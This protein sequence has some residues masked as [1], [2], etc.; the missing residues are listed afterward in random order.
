MA[1]EYV[2]TVGSALPQNRVVCPL[3]LNERPFACMTRAHA[4]AKALIR[5]DPA[6]WACCACNNLMSQRYEDVAIPYLKPRAPAKLY[7]MNQTEAEA[8]DCRFTAYTGADGKVAVRFDPPL[9]E[10]K[11]PAYVSMLDAIAATNPPNFKLT[12]EIVEKPDPSYLDGAIASWFWFRMFSQLGYQ[13]VKSP[14][15][16]PIRSALLEGSPL[17]CR[18]F[19]GQE[20]QAPLDQLVLWTDHPEKSGTPSGSFLGWGLSIPPYAQIAVGP[21]GRPQHDTRPFFVVWALSDTISIPDELTP[22]AAMDRDHALWALS[23]SRGSDK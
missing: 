8:A 1:S 4:P 20:G 16:E 14:Q 22:L 2:S 18:L 9:D 11:K 17:L 15:L 10:S 23:V 12:Y 5:S 19:R 13:A 3:C 6:T 7:L 21:Q